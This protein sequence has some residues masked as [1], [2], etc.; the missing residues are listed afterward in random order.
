MP[1]GIRLLSGGRPAEGGREDEQA[2]Q[3]F[4]FHVV[5]GGWR[6]YLGDSGR[7]ETGI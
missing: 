5:G 1:Q 2:K 3:G 4:Y 7:L 6:G